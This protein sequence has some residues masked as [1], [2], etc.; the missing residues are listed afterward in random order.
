MTN[1]LTGWSAF[2]YYRTSLLVDVDQAGI[3]I[4]GHSENGLLLLSACSLP[5]AF[6]I[7]TP[8]YMQLLACFSCLVRLSVYLS[9]C[10]PAC[11]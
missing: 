7:L 11:L 6:F 9:L 4:D 8:E 3:Y 2:S 1:S 10:L 5:I